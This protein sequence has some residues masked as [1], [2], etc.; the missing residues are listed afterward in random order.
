MNPKND[1]PNIWPALRDE[2]THTA[3]AEPTLAAYLQHFVLAHPHFAAALGGVLAANMAADLVPQAN[4]SDLFREALADEPGIIEAAV[5]DLQAHLERDP[6]SQGYLTPFLYYKGY[7]ALQVH[8]IAHWL[9]R[10]GRKALA[11]HLQSRA[12]QEYDIDIHPAACIG[13]GIMI[14][15]GSGLVI[16]ETAVVEDDVSMLHG[17]TLGGTGKESGDRHPKIRRGVLLAAGARILGNIEVGEG[18]KVGASSLVLT[19]VP[20]HRTYAGVP[21]RDVGRPQSKSPALEMNQNLN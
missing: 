17:V 2:A 6:A 8:R 20:P 13:K 5:A 10:S 7:Q 11:R 21:A 14:D 18:A 12:A 19:S 15:H 9:W 1:R 3:A 4:L 16:G